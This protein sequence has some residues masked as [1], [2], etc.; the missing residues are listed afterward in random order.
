MAIRPDGQRALVG[1]FQTGNV[2]VLDLARQQAFAARP[3]NGAFAGLAANQFSAIAGVSRAPAMDTHL[4]PSCGAI[5]TALVSDVPSP[6]E[7]LLFTWDVQ[8]TR[9]NGRFAVATHGGV[10]TPR[11]YPTTV[12]DLTVALNA[13]L[14]NRLGFETNGSTAVNASGEVATSGQPFTFQRRGRDHLHHDGALTRDMAHRISE[15]G[16]AGTGGR[17]HRHPDGDSRSA[18]N[19]RQSR[20]RPSHG[21]ATRPRPTP[22]RCTG[23]RASA[24]SRSSGSTRRDSAIT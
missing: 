20:A 18:D 23:R 10:G 22:S 5:G 12:P 9:S 21:G 1:M 13:G 19:L 17:T 3:G 11:P 2:A 14:F 16:G 6:D 7:S 8:D 24:S 15:G 4:W